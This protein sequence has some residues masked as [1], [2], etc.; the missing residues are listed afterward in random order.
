MTFAYQILYFN[1]SN[2]GINRGIVHE[3]YIPDV[4]KY[5]TQ[6]RWQPLV[7]SMHHMGTCEG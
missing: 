4:Y 2:V 6:N 5:L 3:N 1:E 7:A